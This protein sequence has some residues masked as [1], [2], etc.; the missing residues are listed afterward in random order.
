MR[1]HKHSEPCRDSEVALTL[2]P[3]GEHTVVTVTQSNLP[4]WVAASVATFVI[5]GQQIVADLIL[6]IE[7]GV[8]GHASLDAMGICRIHG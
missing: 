5:G 8:Q 3:D 7:Q 1:V 6:Y 2:A 4:D